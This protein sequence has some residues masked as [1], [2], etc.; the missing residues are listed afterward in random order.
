MLRLGGAII[1]LDEDLP[2]SSAMVLCRRNKCC[3]M[4]AK[5]MFSIGPGLSFGSER[6][7][8]NL[9]SVKR[10]L[11]ALGFCLWVA[12]NFALAAGPHLGKKGGPGKKGQSAA[13]HPPLRPAWCG[14]D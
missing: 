6:F 1:R 11:L 5:R 10:T 9:F 13:T 14:R 8:K 12:G 4:L 2:A 3:L 7:M